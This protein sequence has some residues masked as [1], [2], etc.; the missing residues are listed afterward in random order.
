MALFLFPV[1]NLIKL[2][3][4]FTVL[5]TILAIVFSEFY[6]KL[7]IS[8]KF[9][10]FG[11]YIFS[12]FNQRFYVELFYNKY[13]TDVILKL[14][15]QTTKVLDKGSIELLGPFGLEKGLLFL[16][17]K[18]ASLDTGVITSYA[19]YIT[20][21][22]IFY[23]SIPYLY[24]NNLLVIIIFAL[25]S[26]FSF[27]GEVK[28]L[29]VSSDENVNKYRKQATAKLLAKK[30]SLWDSKVIKSLLPSINLALIISLAK[31][32]A[33]FL[34]HQLDCSWIYALYCIMFIYIFWLVRQELTGKSEKF[35]F[36]NFAVSVFFILFFTI[37]YNLGCIPGIG[38]II[39]NSITVICGFICNMPSFM[40]HYHPVKLGKRL[41]QEARLK[42]PSKILMGMNLMEDDGNSLDK[43]KGRLSEPSTGSASKD[44]ISSDL[45]RETS[46]ATK[47][48][49]T[50][51]SFYQKELNKV[52]NLEYLIIWIEKNSH[53]KSLKINDENAWSQIEE[54]IKQHP[55][56]I[57][58]EILTR[59]KNVVQNPS[60]LHELLVNEY[61]ERITKLS[62]KALED[63]FITKKFE[64]TM[65]TP[66]SILANISMQ[67]QIV[68]IEKA[69]EK[70][71]L[72]TSYN[73]DRILDLFAQDK[74]TC[75]LIDEIRKTRGN[76]KLKTKKSTTT[77]YNSWSLRDCLSDYLKELKAN[78]NLTG[79]LDSSTRKRLGEEGFDNTNKKANSI[80]EQIPKHINF[81]NT[82]K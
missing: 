30:S 64:P 60:L 53:F 36:K 45:N 5:L 22:L 18:I 44:E 73:N 50:S 48:L 4:L 3:P 76:D 66:D 55:Y 35:T 51:K 14:G 77:L 29:S 46:D 47:Q 10:R 54:I 52:K 59:E 26:L 57:T 62:E 16:S 25:F 68:L 56:S 21:G 71:N 42:F 7:L 19:L 65:H 6:P 20:V 81:E 38:Y 1:P 9:T 23:M 13:I 34:A 37:L 80:T 39:G 40:D 79:P 33:N 15:G 12:F 63:K 8:F 58:S 75:L 17:N 78:V 28:E 82:K 2:L 61:K 43:G 67:R 27:T 24:S 49:E 11:Y 31:F 41:G 72:L 32:P 74:E 70:M 69:L